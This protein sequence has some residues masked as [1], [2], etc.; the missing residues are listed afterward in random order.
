MIRTQLV[1]SLTCAVLALAAGCA[2]FGTP[3]V[4]NPV[5]GPPPPRI[6]ARERET[7]DEAYAGRARVGEDEAY[8]A[9]DEG[10]EPPEAGVASVGR[11]RTGAR[12]A[13]AVPGDFGADADAADEGDLANQVVA[14][15]DGR[16]IFAGEVLERYAGQLAQARRQISP[17]E[18]RELRENL[19][20][21][22]LENHVERKLLVTAL[23]S[24]LDSKKQEQLD[25]HLDDLFED[26]ARKLREQRKV[27]S[28]HELD[29][30]LQK[31]KTSLA[32]L[33]AAF[34][35]QRLA[36][37]Y[38]ASK[39]QQAPKTG[40][41][42][43]HDWYLAHLEEYAVPAQVR[44][45]EIVVSFDRHGGKSGAVKVLDQA[46]A[47]LKRGV[48]FDDVAKQHSD[49]PTA[50]KG[51][52][53]DWTQRGSLADG[54]V[55]KLLFSLPTGTVSRPVTGTDALTMVVVNE[56]RDAHHVPFEEVQTEIR[57]KI[58]ADFRKAAVARL[59]DDLRRSATVVT[60]FDGRP[61]EGSAA[62]EPVLPFQ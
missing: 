58:E 48:P 7:E 43:L 52:R 26:E 6:S 10:F 53:W 34:V 13:S 2:G 27:G 24:K 37:E 19:I 45:Q 54:D 21:R 47:E 56:R 49:G 55:E 33:K 30:E 46:V 11:A 22:D 35:N 28:N 61:E 9:Q 16:P 12:T 50:R 44:W 40:R 39:S 32:A 31:Q 4:D 15:V 41:Q 25:K 38:L 3:K 42:E 62:S 36:M 17:R 14:T 20:R 51:G 18:F 57:E 23:R 1:R 59:L 60:M 5:L 29:L 8:A